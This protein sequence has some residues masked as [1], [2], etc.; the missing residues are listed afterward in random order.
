M[1]TLLAF[2]K[3]QGVEKIQ[4]YKGDGKEFAN[5]GNAVVII[6]PKFD[7]KLEAFVA[8]VTKDKLG[9]AIP[10]G[11]VY[12]VCNSTAKATREL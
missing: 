4:F 3:R 12:A 7:A 5:I 10:A 1:E 2:K 8:E 11:T 9:N 6:S